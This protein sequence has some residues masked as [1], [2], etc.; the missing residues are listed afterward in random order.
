MPGRVST[1]RRRQND[2]LAEGSAELSEP[3]AQ[4]RRVTQQVVGTNGIGLQLWEGTY[5]GPA[6]SQRFF[7]LLF[8]Q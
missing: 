6:S 7:G 5:S 3:F 2:A 8:L 4:N 1:G